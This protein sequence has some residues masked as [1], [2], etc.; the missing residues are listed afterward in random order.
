[1][2]LWRV[3]APAGP[4]AGGAPTPLAGMPLRGPAA[5][6]SG[7]A[8][9]PDGREL[10]ASSKDFKIWLWRVAGDRAVPDGALTGATNW[11]NTVAFSPDGQSLAAGTSVANVLVWNMSTRK[12][13]ATLPH[14]QPVTSVAWAGAGRVVAAGADGTVS[15][16]A[17]PSM[18]LP[19]GSAP[20]Q[21]AYGP[22]GRTLA[23]GGVGSVQLWDTVTRTLL[24]ARPLPPS[25]YANATVFRPSAA[26]G[27]LLAVAVSNGTVAL[28]N[29]STLA[30]VTAP[31]TVITGSGAAESVAF[32]PDG[33][34]LATGADDGTVR[35]FDVTNPARPRQVAIVRG[36]GAE[37]PIYTVAFAPDGKTIAAASLNDV[38]QLWRVTGGDGLAPEAPDL[39]GM[40]S[41][42]I[43]LAFSPDGRTLAIGNADKHVYLW[44]MAN[45]AR[46]R[47]LGAPLSGPTSNVWSVAFSPDGKTLAGSANDG[48]VWLWSMTDPA[49]PALTAT[50]TGLPGHV[51]SV[52]FSPDGAQLAAASY[53]DD[54]V[55]LWDTN[56]AAARAAICS[57][58]G[59]PITSAQW[60]GYAPGVPYR[61]PCS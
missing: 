37:S 5:A 3:P 8:F 9:S 39:G 54:T 57:N 41:Y 28:L 15:L 40:A 56:P 29:G 55:R 19:I 7:V 36:A 20:T 18:V 17:L 34:L 10:A 43:G 14:P 42:P 32:S 49:R 60:A 2:W 26:G 33:R 12:L 35:L 11:A 24:V 21:L 52:V 45:P 48:T 46:P 1:V 30:P 6:V 58:L 47:L 13:T 51:F 25:D 50:L 4:A 38:V 59:Q 27:A 22:G 16:W 44:N 53:D 31:F 61:A 23:V